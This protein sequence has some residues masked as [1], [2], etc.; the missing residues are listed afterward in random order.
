M[1]ARNEQIQQIQVRN[2]QMNECNRCNRYKQERN[3]QMQER[4]E[5]MQERNEQM[6]ERNE[7]MQELVEKHYEFALDVAKKYA[8]RY[9]VDHDLATNVAV[10]RLIKCANVG[11]KCESTGVPFEGYLE[12]SIRLDILHTKSRKVIVSSAVCDFAEVQEH[13]TRRELPGF[14][15][16]LMECKQ[17][18][19]FE[20]RLS[21]SSFGA[22]A[23]AFGISKKRTQ[24]VKERIDANM[25]T[26]ASYL[27]D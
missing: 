18:Q 17:R 7:Q 5:Q 21:G 8:Y 13:S 19:I 11:D 16:L 2:E 1:Q 24:I 15:G 12:R 3:E 26:I 20:A 9:G 23:D 4:N 27:A 6:Q 25:A 10:E 14:M 22:I